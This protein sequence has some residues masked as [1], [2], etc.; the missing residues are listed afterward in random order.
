M[1]FGVMAEERC[2]AEVAR[3]LGEEYLYQTATAENV[4]NVKKYSFDKVITHCPHCFNTIKNE[5]PQFEGNFEVLHHSV[6]IAELVRSGRVKPTKATDRSVAF[7]DSCYLG[8]YNGIF[9][10]PRE[11]ARSVPGLRL[12]ELPRNRERGLCCGGGGGQMWMETPAKKRV[13]V[14]RVEEALGAK[15]DV[16]GVACPF[17]LAMVDLG[18]KVAGAEETLQVK[19]ISELV[20]ESL[21]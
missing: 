6:V 9:E 17:C 3:R 21:E 14:I 19:D 18:R 11:T 7:H 15:P 2:H 5:Y 16:V 1:S 4:E 13:N 20:A 10:A 8:R 12:I